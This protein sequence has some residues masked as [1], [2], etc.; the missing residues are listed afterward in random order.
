MPTIPPVATTRMAPRSTFKRRRSRPGTMPWGRSGRRASRAPG[1]GSE[2]VGRVCAVA[3]RGSAGS[4]AV[5][6]SFGAGRSPDSEEEVTPRTVLPRRTPASRRDV[7]RRFAASRSPLA[8]ETALERRPRG[9]GT[10]G[11]LTASRR[12]PRAG[13]VSR[14]GASARFGRRRTAVR[15]QERRIAHRRLSRRDGAGCVLG[16]RQGFT[17]LRAS[18]SRRR[19]A[20]GLDVVAAGRHGLGLSGRSGRRSAR[21][22]RRRGRHA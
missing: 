14:R 3:S 6:C 2:R 18:P 13:L 9:G 15:P 5:G 21:P 4:A 7:P 10:P 8:S 16:R 22:A 1:S 17:R 11:A 19:A 20:P 12:A